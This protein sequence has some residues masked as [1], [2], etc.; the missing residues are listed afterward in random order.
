[1]S[2][3]IPPLFRKRD[4]KPSEPKCYPTLASISQPRISSSTLSYR[5]C[6]STSTIAYE[7]LEENDFYLYFRSSFETLF[8]RSSV[9]CIP[10]SRRLHG[11]TFNRHLIEA[12]SFRPSPY[13]QGQYQSSNAKVIAID[14]D[15]VVTISAWIAFPVE[16]RVMYAI[17]ADYQ[18]YIYIGYGEPKSIRILNEDLIYLDSQKIRVLLVDE[19]LE[20]GANLSTNNEPAGASISNGSKTIAVLRSF[21]TE[22]TETYVY[23]PGY[24]DHTKEKI[25]HICCRAFQVPGVKKK[26]FATIIAISNLKSFKLQELQ[27]T[28]NIESDGVATWTDYE[29]QMLRELIENLPGFLSADDTN[30]E[31]LSIAYCRD[32]YALGRYGVSGRLSSMPRRYL[33]RAIGCL[34]Q[35][36]ADKE[37]SRS[38][39]YQYDEE[40]EEETMNFQPAYTPIE[41]LACSK[42]TLDLISRAAEKYIMDTC[43]E[44]AFDD[45]FVTTDQLIPLVMYVIVH[46]RIPRL[47][48][49]LYYMKHF[50]FE[51]GKTAELDFALVTM[52]AAVEFLRDD[53]LSLGE[54]CSISSISS[55]SSTVMR[56]S[57]Q[58]RR[59]SSSLSTNVT[60]PISTSS[61][62][63][64]HFKPPPAGSSNSS[65]ALSQPA[66]LAQIRHRKSVS[67]DLCLLAGHSS[68][69][70]NVGSPWSRRDTPSPNL[71]VRP[72][73]VIPK[74]PPAEPSSNYRRQSW[75]WSDH[76]GGESRQVEKRS[77]M[78]LHSLVSTNSPSIP[79]S[80][81]FISSDRPPT[82]ELASSGSPMIHRKASRTVS[83]NMTS[84]PPK[85][86]SVQSNQRL[87]NRAAYR[88]RSLCFDSLT[89]KNEDGIGDFLSGLQNL[90][91]D[92]VGKR[93]GEIQS[94][95]NW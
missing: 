46:A 52:T 58:S 37:G 63:A 64:L 56:L 10:S 6:N 35:V 9:V 68:N 59:R 36:D 54:A 72:R 20:G 73:I 84:P 28:T 43:L 40:E 44:K 11:V 92:V 83:L 53:P 4:K 24:T 87:S 81:R 32:T 39:S 50:T 7:E 78:Y 90:G 34:K 65:E 66:S 25:C 31:A 79:C 41:K 94:L 88:P 89:N 82:F 85:V 48:S 38:I 55:T 76:S 3:S 70:Y 67:A 49:L 74:T 16:F 2:F 13:Y 5:S 51:V 57:S 29:T 80:D 19:L 61:C 21:I 8:K 69:E 26:I 12:H 75:D 86:I 71:V 93:T 91:G 14:E 17:D 1:M 18:N 77:S 47:A 95:R 33:N 15:Y 62:T 27:T 42:M 22:F 23:L 30:L 45:D 60:S